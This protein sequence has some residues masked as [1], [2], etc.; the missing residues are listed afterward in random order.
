M[1]QQKLGETSLD[2]AESLFIRGQ[3]IQVLLRNT[4]ADEV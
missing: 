3:I 2:H 1:F 4:I